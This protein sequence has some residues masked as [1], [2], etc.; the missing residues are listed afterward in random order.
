M[1]QFRNIFDQIEKPHLFRLTSTPRS[2][3]NY[4]EVWPVPAQILSKLVKKSPSRRLFWQAAGG[5]GSRPPGPRPMDSTKFRSILP[6]LANPL[7]V[8]TCPQYIAYG[9]S[10]SRLIGRPLQKSTKL[11]T[12][13]DDLF[14][15][16]WPNACNVPII[17][18]KKLSNLDHAFN[19]V[20]QQICGVNLIK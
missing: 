10:D 5:D 16:I 8:G 3:F 14:L 12:W 19:N 18:W 6:N 2:A 17:V 9:W 7:R 1:T 4:L 15:T 20:F 13:F 11:P